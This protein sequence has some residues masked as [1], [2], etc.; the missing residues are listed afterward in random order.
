MYYDSSTISGDTCAVLQDRT[1]IAYVLYT[2]SL[3]SSCVEVRPSVENK[4]QLHNGLYILAFDDLWFMY[5]L[6]FFIKIIYFN[7]SF[8][9]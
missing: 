9:K 3:R 5:Y 4:L 1:T 2:V 6:F 8:Q 7:F